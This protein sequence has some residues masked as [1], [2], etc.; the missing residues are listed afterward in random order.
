MIL[1]EVF[2]VG[3]GHCERTEMAGSVCTHTRLQGTRSGLGR[4]ISPPCLTFRLRGNHLPTM[5]RQ[6]DAHSQK[7]RLLIGES[8]LSCSDGTTVLSPRRLIMWFAGQSGS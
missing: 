8:L 4:G 1:E 2:Q 5:G 7:N 3:G 6:A